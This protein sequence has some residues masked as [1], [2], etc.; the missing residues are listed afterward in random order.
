MVS[1]RPNITLLFISEAKMNEVVH[2]PQN[3]AVHCI[4]CYLDVHLPYKNDFR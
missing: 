3:A 1:S 2:L 4:F